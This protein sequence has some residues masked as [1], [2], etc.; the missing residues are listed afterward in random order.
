MLIQIAGS[1]RRTLPPSSEL[2]HKILSQ[3]AQN[4]RRT[5][6][7]KTIWQQTVNSL[8]QVLGVTRCIIC[9][10]KE[11]ENYD[12]SE[13]KPKFKVVAEYCQEAYS[14]MLGLELSEADQPGWSQALATL[15]PVAVERTPDT[16]D[17]FERYSVLVAATSYQDQ[18]NALICLHQSNTVRRWS[19]VEVE[20]CAGVSG[21]SWDCDRSRY[22]LSRIRTSSC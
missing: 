8:G 15:E 17:P 16:K 21:T 7:L 3:I 22:S 18:P 2:Y 14:S 6:D 9:A 11:E 5:L 20:F 10:Y 12:F 13:L 1:I 19:A 4:I